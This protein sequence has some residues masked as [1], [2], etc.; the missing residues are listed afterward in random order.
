MQNQY[1]MKSSIIYTQIII[2]IISF[3]EIRYT[4]L[5]SDVASLGQ[6]IRVVGRTLRYIFDVFHPD[7][8]R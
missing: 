7:Q 3:I 4:Q 8:P 5:D 6:T 1:L 2:F